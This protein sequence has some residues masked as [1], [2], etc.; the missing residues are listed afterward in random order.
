MSINLIIISRYSNTNYIDNIKSYNL[1][2]EANTNIIYPT[3]T[4]YETSLIIPYLKTDMFNLIIYDWSTTFSS[5]VSDDVNQI[6]TNTFDVVYLGK[7]LDTCNNYSVSKSIDNFS[8]VTG[9]DPVGFNAVLITGDF[10]NKM[11][12]YLQSGKYYTIA[13]TIGDMSIETTVNSFAVSPNM[14]VYN[15]LYNSIDTSKSFSVKTME[16]Q[17]LNSQINPPSDNNLTIFWIILIIIGVCFIIWAMLIYTPLG[18]NID[19]FNKSNI[20]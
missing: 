7:Y 5:N 4:Q 10:A 18:I 16:C 17:G 8:L 11:I 9:T 19:K 3:D 6:L 2:L 12:P 14:F 1:A 20:T 13:Y 15:P